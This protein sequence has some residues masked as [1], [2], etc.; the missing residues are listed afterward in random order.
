MD[1][2]QLDNACFDSGVQKRVG[3]ML[4]SNPGAPLVDWVG[5]QPEIHPKK[6]P[7]LPLDWKDQLESWF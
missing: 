7:G 3:G 1:L 4:G 6:W 2:D 5:E